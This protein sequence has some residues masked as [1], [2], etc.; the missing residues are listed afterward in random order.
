MRAAF[1]ELAGRGSEA[2][3]VSEAQLEGLASRC[4]GP[5][6]RSGDPGWDEAVLIWNGMT[7][8]VPRLVVQPN[9]VQ[10]VVAAVRFAHDH[11]LRLGI[12]GSATISQVLPLLTAVSPSTCRRCGT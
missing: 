3:R 8:G 6:L 11:G 7:A 10:D 9:S 12:K 1:I 2:V 5:L 4:V